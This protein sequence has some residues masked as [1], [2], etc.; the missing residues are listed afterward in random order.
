MNRELRQFIARELVKMA[1]EVSGGAEEEF[2]NI[3]KMNWGQLL[4]YINKHRSNYTTMSKSLKMNKFKDTVDLS[5]PL[6]GMPI[7]E[8][9]KTLAKLGVDVDEEGE[10]AQ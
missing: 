2:D 5:K 7:I 6:R 8:V 3:D 9:F 1:A 4:R 10:N